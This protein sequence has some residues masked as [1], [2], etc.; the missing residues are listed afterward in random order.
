M[1][2]SDQYEDLATLGSV[3]LKQTLASRLPGERPLVEMNGAILWTQQCSSG[4]RSERRQIM[5]GFR[6][7]LG[8][9]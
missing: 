9:V 8:E 6:W 3:Q 5:N 2:G 4:V 7:N 1:T